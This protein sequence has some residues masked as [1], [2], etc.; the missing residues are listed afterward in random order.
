LIYCAHFINANAQPSFGGGGGGGGGGDG[1]GD[2]GESGFA[3]PRH[4]RAAEP[5]RAS[6]SGYPPTMLAHMGTSAAPGVAAHLAAAAAAPGLSQS[7]PHAAALAEPAR[8]TPEHLFECSPPLAFA[9]P[10]SPPS[11]R[12]YSMIVPYI[13]LFFFAPPSFLSC[14]GLAVFFYFFY[15]FKFSVC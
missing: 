3:A 10:L 6:V 15:P 2:Y 14:D 12:F 4:L 11:S 7:L 5:Q 1:Y 13:V 9:L 8:F